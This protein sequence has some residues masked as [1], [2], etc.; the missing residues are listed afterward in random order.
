VKPTRAGAAL[1]TLATLVLAAAPAPAQDWRAGTGRLE[2]RVLDGK[3]QPVASAD[4]KLELQGRG[5]TTLHPDGKGRWAILGLTGGEWTV[6]VSAPGFTTARRT[7]TVSE[8]GRGAPVETRLEAAQGPP[9]EVLAAIDKAEAAYEAGRYGDARREYE[10]LLR[11]RP[12]LAGRIHQQIGF[13][14]VQEKDWA[15]ALEALQQSLAA[16]PGNVAARIAAVQAAFA[17]GRDDTA[18]ELVS[19]T[20]PDA[21]SAPD[22]AFN[23]GAALLNAGATREAIPWLSRSVELDSRYVDGYY[24]R[25]LAR[26]QLGEAAE[27]RADFGKVIE[28]APGSKEAELARKALEQVR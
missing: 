12:D 25:A 23:V 8:M 6:E 14:Y 21:V 13:T 24:R 28:L 1:V 2:G 5:G 19:R 9:P 3:G 11:L 27:S 22:L 17:A 16:E 20:A 10:A 18:R 4:V 15:R 26:L 7:V